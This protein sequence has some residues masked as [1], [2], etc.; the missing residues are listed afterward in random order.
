MTAHDLFDHISTGAWH[1]LYVLSYSVVLGVLLQLTPP[2]AGTLSIIW[3]CLQM[4]A[5]FRRKA[6]LTDEE[7]NSSK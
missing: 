1:L 4:F 7:R 2:I 3:L 6:W 5:Y